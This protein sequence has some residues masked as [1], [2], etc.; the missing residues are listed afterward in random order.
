MLGDK[1]NLNR[2]NRQN[3]IYKITQDVDLQGATLAI[4]EGCSLDFQGGRM[5]NGTV[6]GTIK[7][8]F[9]YI[10]DFLNGNDYNS[11]FNT[12]KGLNP[13]GLTVK[14]KKDVVLT[15]RIELGR[16]NLTIDG[17]GHTLSIS[18]VATAY[19]L[20]I[21]SSTT[22]KNIT[23]KNIVFDVSESGCI[24]VQSTTTDVVDRITIEN[25]IFNSANNTMDVVNIVGK[26]HDITV[27]NNTFN[28]QPPAGTLKSTA[29]KLQI[30]ET[31]KYSANVRVIGN[32]FYNFNYTVDNWSVG[33]FADFWFEFNYVEG[34]YMGIRNYH[35]LN[36]FI[37]NN[38]FKGNKH[39]SYIWQAAQ[40]TNN[41]WDECGSEVESE[42]HEPTSVTLEASSG[43]F[44]GNK[45]KSSR[46]H[47]MTITGGPTGIISNN[48]FMDIAGN[49]IHI[50]TAIYGD[51]AN[52]TSITDNKF[53]G[54]NK[55]GIYL[56]PT[57]IV[58]KL[59]IERNTIVGIGRGS[60]EYNGIECNGSL[61]NLFIDNNVI[62]GNDAQ[63]GISNSYVKYGISINTTKDSQRFV[64]QSNNIT[65]NTCIQYT[66]AS[67]RAE[68]IN[69]ILNYDALPVE[70][71]NES[72]YAKK[73]E[74]GNYYTHR[75][76]FGGLQ[77]DNQD[78]LSGSDCVL[79]K[80]KGKLALK[81]VSP[82]SIPTSAFN[83]TQFPLVNGRKVVFVI[84][85]G[86][87]ASAT[88]TVNSVTTTGA[89]AFSIAGTQVFSIN[90][91]EGDTP[92][93]V[94]TKICDVQIP[95]WHISRVS[96]NQFL[97][98]RDTTDAFSMSITSTGNLNISSTTANGIAKVFARA[99]SFADI[100]RVG[101]FSELDRGGL[102]DLNNFVSQVG[103]Q[104]Y[105]TDTRRP[106]FFN[107]YG[108]DYTD[109]DGFAFNTRRGTTAERPANPQEGFLYY[110]STIK[111]TIMWNGSAWTNVD[112]TA[113]S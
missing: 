95:T 86:T 108:V 46:G 27:Q 6:T 97:I 94:V 65:A 33:Y 106:V 85:G 93:T 71:S 43:I 53:Y 38:I 70:G 52:T 103:F 74:I 8:D 88:V 60:Q 32:N 87:P 78:K 13:D 107:G 58:G 100:S 104:Y 111:K 21:L 31:P 54:I 101:K 62:Y 50:D 51:M 110:D 40:C 99:D 44:S 24:R 14:F 1:M 55:N 25:C 81:E 66:M 3:V 42:G 89:E 36:S 4:P 109:A 12:I 98:E 69:N 30:M 9:V 23:F 90:V 11:A 91:E 79:M 59:L 18:G 96:D 5:I 105:D 80:E 45:I 112:G 15:Q 83:P 48:F 34:G 7:N 61:L 56:T 64:L 41:L 29:V 102:L 35:M 77:I 17:D 63:Y 49:G 113:L 2:F 57:C 92:T 75:T 73:V 26:I 10:E 39:F 20:T 84:T 22:V 82:S 67:G 16:D 47:G 19:I 28:N 72:M 68:I 37:N 76:Y